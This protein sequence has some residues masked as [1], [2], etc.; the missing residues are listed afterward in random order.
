MQPSPIKKS[1]LF[2]VRSG[3]PGDLNFILATWLRGLRYGNPLFTEIDKDAYFSVYH[4]VIENILNHSRVKVAC[5]KD[6]QDVILGYSVIQ[7][8]KVHWVHVKSEWRKIGIARSLLTE[9][10]NVVTHLTT[11]GLQILKQRCPSV[12]FNPFI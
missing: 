8:D 9:K 4:K 12:K 2:T 6:D 5:L 3:L 11:L 10:F 7:A 1:D